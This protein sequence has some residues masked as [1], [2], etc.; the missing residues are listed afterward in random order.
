MPWAEG[1]LFGVSRSQFFP[2]GVQSF[3]MTKEKTDEN[4]EEYIET[5]GNPVCS[6][7]KTEGHLPW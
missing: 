6:T 4:N 3:E 2:Q 1:K 5:E 7:V